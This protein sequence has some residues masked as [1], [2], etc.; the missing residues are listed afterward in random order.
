MEWRDDGIILNVRKHGESG[1][2]VSLITRAHGRHAGLVR[3]GRSSRLRGILQPGNL[4][5]ADWRARL[6]EHLGN[7]T[8]EPMESRVA[9]IL[10]H[11]GRLAALTSACAILETAL[12][13]RQSAP[14]MFDLMDLLT[15]HLG[16]DDWAATYVRWEAAMLSAL[17]FGLDLT[18][19]A[20]TGVTDNLTYVSPKTARAVSEEAAGPYKE[21]LLP[22]PPFLLEDA[23]EGRVPDADEIR[24]GLRLTG[25]FLDQMVMGPAGKH[26]PDERGRI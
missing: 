9:P 18:A 5:R 16:D 15:R 7:M 12:P 2:I 1:A 4:I 24:D 22:L 6:I 20:A 17:G 10:L 13:E 23:E 3:G 8:V 11:P 19:C 21:R 26:L 14:E 25:F